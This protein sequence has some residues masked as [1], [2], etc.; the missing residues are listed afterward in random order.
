M[1]SETSA[2]AMAVMPLSMRPT[3]APPTSAEADSS[4]GVQSDPNDSAAFALTTCCLGL[5]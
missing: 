4:E 2:V 5:V 3:I 1:Q